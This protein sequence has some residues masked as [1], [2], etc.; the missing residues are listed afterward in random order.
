[1]LDN[2]ILMMDMWWIY[3]GYTMDSMMD[4]MMDNMMDIWWIYDGYMMDIRWIIWWIYDGLYDGYMMIYYIH[5]ECIVYGCNVCYFMK[6]N[7]LI[8]SRSMPCHVRSCK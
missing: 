1:M 5:E 2:M 6:N 3:D 4:N 8:Q 7:D